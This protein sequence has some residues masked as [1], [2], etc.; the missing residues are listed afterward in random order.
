M[1]ESMNKY[2]K[3]SESGM[4]P[5]WVK[6]GALAMGVGVGGWSP[7]I[8]KARAGKRYSMSFQKKGNESRKFVFS[9]KDL[10][11]N[12]AVS[13]TF[14]GAEKLSETGGVRD[15]KSCVFHDSA[16][17]FEVGS[18]R[19]DYVFDRSVLFI[20]RGAL[21]QSLSVESSEHVT[22]PMGHKFFADSVAFE[23]VP[24][25]KSKLCCHLFF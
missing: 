14:K 11:A 13:Y 4:L 10:D 8:E 16:F 21:S 15:L 23:N 6:V 18:F 17:V 24:L 22:I 3:R 1:S 9:L 5:G 12:E 20:S 2:H 19:G 7:G 25:V